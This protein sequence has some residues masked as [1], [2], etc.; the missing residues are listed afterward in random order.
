LYVALGIVAL[1]TVGFFIFGMVVTKPIAGI[2]RSMEII[3]KELVFDDDFFAGGSSHLG[4]SRVV[5]YG[6]VFF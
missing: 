2:A 3:T 4:T 1:A 5:L 6:S